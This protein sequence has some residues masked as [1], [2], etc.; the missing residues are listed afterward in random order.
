MDNANGGKPYISKDYNAN[1]AQAK[2]LLAD[3][4]YPDG[5]GLPTITY[6]TNDAGY[7]KVVAQYLQQAWALGVNMDISVVEWAS[8]TPQRR[9]GDYEISRNGWLFDYNDPSNMLDLMYSTNGNNDGKYN[10]PDYD[11]AMDKAAAEVDPKTRSGYLH[12]AEDMHDGRRLLHPRRLLQRLLSHAAPRS[13]ATGTPPTASGTSSCRRGRLIA[14][15]LQPSK[16]KRGPARLKAAP[17]PFLPAS[18]FQ[19]PGADFSAPA[20]AFLQSPC[21][22]SPSV[23]W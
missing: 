16:G 19:S 21:I 8:F 14:G 12:Q 10:N 15:R 18:L 6:S 1:L 11:A 20:A 5:K 2:Q 22:F 3:A 9:A 13:P 4:G 17:V 23:L 7:H